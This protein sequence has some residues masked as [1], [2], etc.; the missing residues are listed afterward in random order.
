MLCGLFHTVR[1]DGQSVVDCIT[2]CYCRVSEEKKC[3]IGL[4][5]D[6][7]GVVSTVSDLSLQAQ[8]CCLVCI[9]RHDGQSVIDCMTKCYCPVSDLLRQRRLCC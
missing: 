9:V 7:T 8:L 5:V 4:N 1:H 3:F 6:F 2:K